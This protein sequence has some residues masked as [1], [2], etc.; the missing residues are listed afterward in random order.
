MAKNSGF[1]LVDWLNAN[2][3]MWIG[4]PVGSFL[5]LIIVLCL[6]IG[7]KQQRAEAR[8]KRDWQEHMQTV[9]GTARWLTLDDLAAG[10]NIGK[11]AE[12]LIIGKC[13]TDELIRFGK[14]GHLL[15]FAPTGA[16]KGVSTLMPNLLD[17]QGSV[18]VIDPK[19]ENAAV[20][21]R[22]RREMGQIV[23]ILDPFGKTGMA[24]G[25]FNPLVWLDPDGDTAAEQSAL[26][27]EALAPADGRSSDPF[28]GNEARAILQ[29]LLLYIAAH[30]P[31]GKKHLG[32]LRDCLNLP[33]EKWAGL[34]ES[35]AESPHPLIAGAANRFKQKAEK[36]ASSVLSTAASHT[37]FL[38]SVPLRRVLETSTID[39]LGIKRQP[40]T[41]Y[42]VLPAEY[43]KTHA[44]WL[45]L[46]VSMLLQAVTADATERPKHDVLFMLDEFAALGHLPMIQTA[47]GLMRGYGLKI[48]PIL[49]DL[50]Q[51]QAIYHDGW[52]SFIANAGVVQAFGTNDKA[53]ALYLSQMMGQTTVGTRSDNYNPQSGGSEGY[54][55]TGRALMMPDEVQRLENENAIVLMRGANPM[56]CERVIY[57]KDKRFSKHA[58]RNPYLPKNT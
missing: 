57:W 46:M 39:L 29:G 2:P 42:L 32:T 13:G 14:D 8:K 48:W 56:I 30:M 37:H 3:I 36:E 50:P 4:L 17:Y 51:L 5:V 58:D 55:Y 44:R 18:V 12:G 54:S 24:S 49:Q 16:G 31:E 43:L 19:G 41:V 9:H 15:T 53:T 20:T 10:H 26:L 7:K 52:Q 34:L 1:W 6:W 22:R 45:R 35:M 38:D 11:K 21:A 33:P 23:H 47:F 28:W 27:A 25:S 40:M